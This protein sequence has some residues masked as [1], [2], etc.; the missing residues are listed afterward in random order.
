MENHPDFQSIIE[1]VIN[2]KMT[3]REAAKRLKTSEPNFSQYMSRHY[4]KHKPKHRR[5]KKERAVSSIILDKD[6]EPTISVQLGASQSN[7]EWGTVAW[8]KMIQNLLTTL[9]T[10]PNLNL[11]EQV[12][13]TRALTDL[14]KFQFSHIIPEVPQETVQ[15]DE[16]M[17][18][19][20]I[21]QVMTDHDDWCPYRSQFIE[22]KDRKQSDSRLESAK[23]SLME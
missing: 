1:K 9:T 12:K 23:P 21:D 10:E 20:I 19:E 22:G 17:A 6:G 4:P 7:E 3:G 8:K 5:K 11:H 13:L 2:N 15:I 14:L 18:K 16:S